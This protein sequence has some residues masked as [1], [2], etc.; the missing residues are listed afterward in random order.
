M[1]SLLFYGYRNLL[2][3]FFIASAY[4]SLFFGQISHSFVS[5]LIDYIRIIR[6]WLI[7]SKKAL[8]FINNYRDGFEIYFN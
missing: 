2:D 6:W 5:Y 7:N 1:L 8:F 3:S 4:N